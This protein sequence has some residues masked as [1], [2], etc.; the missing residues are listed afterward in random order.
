LRTGDE[1][2][3]S[4]LVGA[5]RQLPGAG[6]L[7]WLTGDQL[8]PPMLDDDRMWRDGGSWAGGA[9]QYVLDLGHAASLAPG[10]HV[11]DIGCGLCGPARILVREFGV[12]V[13][14]ITN[15]RVHVEQSRRLNAEAG[16]DGAIEVQWVGGLDD[17]PDG[18]YDAAWSLN[19][20]YQ[21]HDHQELYARVA[22]LLRPGGRFL[23][24]DWMA[25]D[26]ITESDLREF[27]YHFQYRNIV[28]LSQLET[29]LAGAGFYPATRVL[30]RGAAGRGPMSRHFDAVMR[31]HF[32]SMLSRQWPDGGPDGLSGRQMALDFAAAV[33]VTLRL[34]REGKLTYRT[35]VAPVRTGREEKRA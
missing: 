2:Y 11:L 26:T 4:D 6:I 25:A 35:V 21:V 10:E 9:R 34:Y 22:D 14:A 32:L 17:W 7:A 3:Q 28:R 18:A 15:S 16:T 5:A 13:T 23:L 27:R 19:M 20:L 8:H 30:D 31:G 1:H 33:A 12:R 24:D 29:N